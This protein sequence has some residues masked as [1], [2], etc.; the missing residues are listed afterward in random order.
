MRAD[1]HLVPCHEKRARCIC[2]LVDASQMLGQ[3]GIFESRLFIVVVVVFALLRLFL[4]VLV[5]FLFLALAFLRL[6]IIFHGLAGLGT[7][8]APFCVSSA[9]LIVGGL[10]RTGS[11]GRRGGRGG[12]YVLR[13]M[14]AIIMACT[15]RRVRHL[16]SEPGGLNMAFNFERRGVSKLMQGQRRSF[17]QPVRGGSL[18]QLQRSSGI[19]TSE[20]PSS[21]VAGT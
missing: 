5:L 3:P 10:W 14:M 4:L 6:A 21:Q 12:G 13:F 1:D 9:G 16:G 11:G 8:S 17:E 18:V 15:R 20:A 7:A 19:E 2:I